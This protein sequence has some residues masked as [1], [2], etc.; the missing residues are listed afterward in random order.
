MVE[1]AALVRACLQPMLMPTHLF[2]WNFTDEIKTISFRTH[3]THR[4][5]HHYSAFT[6]ACSYIRMYLHHPKSTGVCIRSKA[7]WSLLLAKQHCPM[8]DNVAPRDYRYSCT[9]PQHLIE[10]LHLSIGHFA[11]GKGR[12]W[13]T[14]AGVWRV[15]E[16]VWEL[17]RKINTLQL[18]NIERWF[19]GRPAGNQ[20]EIP[21]SSPPAV[22]SADVNKFCNVNIAGFINVGIGN[23]TML[24]GFKHGPV[25]VSFVVEEVVHGRWLR[26]PLSVSFDYRPIIIHLR[27]KEKLIR[28]QLLSGAVQTVA[29]EFHLLQVATHHSRHFAS[30]STL[31]LRNSV[32]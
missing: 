30:G 23:S 9:Q 4:T 19:Q 13:R 18:P 24:P 8:K 28:Y 22:S 29:D 27:L 31:L 5:F 11:P 20:F 2:L 32:S 21:Y 17:P 15:P 16:S 12:K 14:D 25:H 7:G 3:I 26:F 1:V 10:C 6:E